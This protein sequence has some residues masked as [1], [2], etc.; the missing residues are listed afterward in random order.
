MRLIQGSTL[1]ALVCFGLSGPTAQ[2]Q[3]NENY[4]V[5]IYQDLVGRQASRGEVEMWARQLNNREI[6][7]DQFRAHV[8]G[9]EE[10]FRR[11]GRDG[12]RFLTA[13]FMYM[14]GRQP[15]ERDLGYWQSRWDAAGSREAVAY[16]MLQAAS[17]PV[18]REEYPRYDGRRYD[19]RRYDE[20][21]YDQRRYDE[22]RYDPRYEI[23]RRYE[24]RRYD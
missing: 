5:Q 15:T 21:R 24:R 3:V 22:R 20:R 12:R 2:A 17:N 7:H 11:V 9:S 6:G 4:V 19:E 23:Y 14:Y 10:Y 16:E 13:M 8:L 1:A 18:P